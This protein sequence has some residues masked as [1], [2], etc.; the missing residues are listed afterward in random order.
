MQT[1]QDYIETLHLQAGQSKRM[2]CPSCGH[3]G[4]FSVTNNGTELLWNCFHAACTC[5]GRSGVSLSRDNATTI[6]NTRLPTKP[7]PPEEF[8]KPPTWTR[9]L[10]NG[11]ADYFTTVHTTGRYPHL[12]HDVRQNRAVYAIYSPE[13]DLVDGVGRTL[14]GS[15]PKWY[16]YGNYPGGF[17][18]GN[19]QVAVV[20]E[21]VPS[22]VSISDW[23]TGYALMGTQLRDG[24]IGE[25]TSFDHVVIALDKD[26]T[27]KALVIMRELSRLVSCGLLML[28][29]DLKSMGEEERESLIRNSIVRT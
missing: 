22:A 15:R 8:T 25:L 17:L 26:A 2:D 6:F 7:K 13:G 24:H 21:D 27:D 29:R 19:S 5:R 12:Y 1:I 18:W 28:D 9:Q 10:S 4:T 20:V 23:A 16:R 3:H 11:A 14:E